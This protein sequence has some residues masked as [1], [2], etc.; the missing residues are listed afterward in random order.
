M[1]HFTDEKTETPNSGQGSKVRSE[2]ETYSSMTFVESY[3]G[4]SIRD[5]AS[6]LKEHNI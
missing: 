6:A 4:L 5:T 2:A 3:S 1:C